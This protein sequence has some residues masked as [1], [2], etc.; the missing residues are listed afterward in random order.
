MFES[1]VIL[2]IR[3]TPWPTEKDIGSFESYV[4]LETRKTYSLSSSILR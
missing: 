2:E 1:Y 3:K 4:I